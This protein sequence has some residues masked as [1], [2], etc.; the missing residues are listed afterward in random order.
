MV[1]TRP[2]QAQRV[3]KEAARHKDGAAEPATRH[4]S[5]AAKAATGQQ[6]SA[7]KPATGSRGRPATKAAAS[8]WRTR[9]FAELNRD[10]VEL[11]G[12]KTAKALAGLG[13]AT[14]G[15]LLRH[16]PR[17]YLSGTES[18]DLS[19]LKEGQDVAVLVTVADSIVHAQGQ[20]SRLE[21][22]LTDGRTRL[23]AAFFGRERSVEAWARQLRPGAR[24]IFVGR[25][26]RFRDRPQ[27]THPD[28]VLVDEH[29]QVIGRRGQTHE[30]MA[31]QVSR[32]GL[33][34]LYPASSAVP[35]W[36]L[37]E[38]VQLALD[39]V[40]HLADPLPAPVVARL[41]LMGEDDA[42][43][44]AHQ[45][46]SLRDADAACERLRFDEALAVQLVM[47]RRRQLT[48]GQGAPRLQGRQG[49]ILDAFDSALPF[50]LT[51]GQ[52]EV[53]A[54]LFDEIAGDHPMV[55]LL[56]GEVGSGKT[57]VALRAML[58]AVDSGRQAALVA[59]TEVLAGQHWRSITDLLGPLAGGA[60]LGAPEAATGVVL[61]TGSVTGAA[62]RQALA[63]I[64][65]GEAGVVIGT[66]A[67]FQEGVHFRDLGLVVIDEQHRFGVEQRAALVRRPD[68]LRAHQLVMTATPIPRT[69][70]MTAFGDLA[71]STLT[72]L[73]AGRADVQTTVVDTSVHPA[74]VERAWQRIREEV[75]A[76]H[77]AFVVCPRIDPSEPDESDAEPGRPP[78]ASVLEVHE[79]LATGP[80]AGLRVGMLHGR[81]PPEEKESRMR[82]FAEGRTDVLVATTVI[83][84]GLDVPNA[85]VMVVM[86]ADR[87]GI[88]Q[89]HQVRGRIGRGR[90][91]GLCLLLTSS[92]APET[93]ERLDAV[94]ATRDGFRLAELDLAQRREGDVLGSG[95]AGR[96]SSLHLVR[97]VD[98]ADLIEEARGVAADLVAADPE[99]RDD[100]LA[101]LTRQTELQGEEEA[102]GEWLERT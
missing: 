41:G 32:S 44:L 97:V 29:G 99:S 5:S 3:A 84:V 50:Q 93:R 2:A 76:G 11:V 7:A 14:V 90:H 35:T 36:T 37:A 55:R 73:P 80:L 75:D 53:C 74:W 94:A 1:A 96:H 60:T 47:A 28:F 77:Q 48:A 100:L 101:D 45:P 63:A 42:Y 67:L 82:D 81:M 26:G 62:R 54:T 43:H 64:E 91:P 6:N 8:Q 102:S 95:Q 87:F 68:D 25:V 85:T 79:R 57:V 78:A 49:G 30:A 24:G 9:D 12:A 34:G 58:R 72:E 15:D 83:E 52:E 65:S 23:S 10:L 17:R 56:Q 27:L 33:I 92:Q 71:V 16:L 18:S 40:G 13:L 61:L 20:R 21:V 51:A 69:I 46:I 38:C 31:A 59:P 22:V 4:E 88:S 19:E 98:D 89:L 86:D 70:A 39:Q 66:H